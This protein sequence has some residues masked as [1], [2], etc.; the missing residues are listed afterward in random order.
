MKLKLSLKCLINCLSRTLTSFI[1]RHSCCHLVHDST[2]ST[3]SRWEEKG[4]IQ[5]VLSL[6]ENS[7]LLQNPL[8]PR[9]RLRKSAVFHPFKVWMWMWMWPSC[10]NTSTRVRTL[11]TILRIILSDKRIDRQQN[12]DTQHIQRESASYFRF[13]C[14]LCERSGREMRDWLVQSL[15]VSAGHRAILMLLALNRRVEF[16]IRAF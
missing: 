16:G 12:P 6:A 1:I 15:R 8:T 3:S 10:W 14:C 5:N 4:Q 13:L 9:S 2:T 11:A 7:V